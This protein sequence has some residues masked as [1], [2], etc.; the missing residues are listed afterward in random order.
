MSNEPDKVNSGALATMIFLVAL[1][2]LAVALVVTALVRQETARLRAAGDQNQ[3]RPYRQ[4]RSEQESKLTGAPAWV[5]QGAGIASIPI[6]SAMQ[7]VLEGVREN[8]LALSPGN[9]PKEEE[10][11]AD[12][13]EASLADAAP[14]ASTDSAEENKDEK[15]APK[16][17]APAPKAPV[18]AAPAPVPAAPAPAAPAPAPG[19][20]AQ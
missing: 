3:E 2:T 19:G 7:L 18:P 9:K 1:A 5:D 20:P 11:E 13:T 14:E 6:H 4:L 17:V 16:T 12:T 10:E 15:T 8:P